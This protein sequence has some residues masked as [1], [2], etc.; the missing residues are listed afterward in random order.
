MKDSSVSTWKKKYSAE[1]KRV[2]SE[3][4]SEEQ[5]EVRI[6]SLPVKKR[7][8]PLLLGEQLDTAV[9]NYIK[10]DRHAGGVF[11]TS[12][13]IAAATAIVRK[14]DRNLSR[15]RRDFAQ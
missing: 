11:N 12:I 15:Y 6:K 9:K 3:R 8:R 1:L 14:T 4:D 13:M 7:G 5:G 2:M 10:A